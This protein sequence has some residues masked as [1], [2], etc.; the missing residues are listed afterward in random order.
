MTLFKVRQPAQM[1]LMM[2]VLRGIEDLER[3]LDHLPVSQTRQNFLN[4][5]SLVREFCEKNNVR[6]SID[7]SDFDTKYADRLWLNH[8]VFFKRLKDTRPDVWSR[9][10]VLD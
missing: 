10:L 5:V 7:D 6:N 3:A 9:L 2:D 4:D 1:D 8:L